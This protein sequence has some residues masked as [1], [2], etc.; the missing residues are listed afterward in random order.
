MAFGI[1]RFVPGGTK[2]QYDN[3]VAALRLRGWTPTQGLLFHAAG[4]S[5]DGW[6]IVAVYD[7]KA[8]WEHF[9]DEILGPCLRS[10]IAGGF[11]TRPEESE[12]DIYELSR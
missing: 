12:V 3:S 9:R 1:I 8:S 4:P 10:G 7:S 2:E 6:T 11:T 5:G